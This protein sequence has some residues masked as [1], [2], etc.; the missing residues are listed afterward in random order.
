MTSRT[1]RSIPFYRR[2]GFS[3][4]RTFLGCRGSQ[5]AWAANYRHF[6]TAALVVA[7]SWSAYLRTALLLQAAQVLP[8]GKPTMDSRSILD[9]GA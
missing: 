7:P 8:S 4:L 3:E 1:S 6:K 9:A 5:F 2:L